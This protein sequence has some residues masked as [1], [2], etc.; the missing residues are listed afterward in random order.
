MARRRI[1]LK[2]RIC[3]R[4]GREVEE[5]IGGLC[6]ECYVD[7]YRVASIPGRAE[8]IYCKYCGSYKVQGSWTQPLGSIE[9]TLNTY[10]FTYYTKR[11]R[12]TTHIDEAWIEDIIV[13]GNI[14]GPG[15]Y[16]VRVSIKGRS[17]G[18]ILKEDATSI[19]KVSLAVCP[20]CTNRITKRG[21]EAVIQVRGSK[22]R[23]T[24]NMR[25]RVDEILLGLDE[26]MKESI[27]SLEE[28]KEGIDILVQDAATARLIAAKLKTS[29]MARVTETYKLAGRRSDGRRIGKLT[30]AVRI[31]DLNPGDVLSIRGTPHI[32]LG[33]ARSGALV[34]DMESGEEKVVS[35]DELWSGV[36]DHVVVDERR[37]L[38][39]SSTRDNVVF[40]DADRGYRRVLEYPSSLVKVLVGDFKE[41]REFKAY[42][43]GSRV[44]VVKEV[45]EYG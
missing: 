44:Y 20:T 12:P 39:I 37:L 11:L 23:L 10:L 18:L 40:L 32:Y 5:T 8:F 31:P 26:R 34:V 33:Q 6:P 41:G 15:T 29:L 24:S 16:R 27:V 30:L 43:H 45:T 7:V 28:Q 1:K 35:S 2:A 21:Y 14:T 36:R 3:P 38:L 19:V 9:E 22:G 25:S 4:C 17:G 42:I 13:P